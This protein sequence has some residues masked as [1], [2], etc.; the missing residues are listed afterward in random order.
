MKMESGSRCDGVIVP[1]GA[2]MPAQPLT[3][4]DPGPNFDYC[5]VRPILLDPQA[6]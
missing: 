1:L 4:V 5:A 2:G 6:R 3:G